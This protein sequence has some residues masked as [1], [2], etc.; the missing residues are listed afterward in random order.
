MQKIKKWYI[1][2]VVLN[3][4]Y[5]GINKYWFNKISMVN[6]F[7]ALIVVLN[8]TF[9]VFYLFTFP[10]VSLVLTSFSFLFLIP[11]FLNRKRRFKEA[12]FLLILF[13]NFILVYQTFM[14]GMESG[15]YFFYFP[16]FAS[17]FYLFF[18]HEKWSIFITYLYSSLGLVS[19]YFFRDYTG[20][21]EIKDNGFYLSLFKM[22]F[23]FALFSTMVAV[24][25]INHS[26]EKQNAKYE[27]KS[28]DKKKTNKK[29]KGALKEKSVLLAE[30]HHR[31][32][33]NLAVISGLINLQAHLSK[34]EEVKKVLNDSAGRIASMS[35]IHEK[36]YKH[37]DLSNVDMI[38]YIKELTGEIQNTLSD[39][40]TEIDFKYDL[41]QFSLNIIQA[42]P[43]GLIINELITNCLK[44]AFK[45]K[46]HGTVFISSTINAGNVI[47]TVDDD[48]IGFDYEKNKMESS[49]LG[50]I[51][52]ESLVQQLKGISEYSSD[53]G[54][55]TKF[56]LSFTVKN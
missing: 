20:Y 46:S 38:Q 8:M 48:G 15:N 9:A 28:E 5:P 11:Y 47:I 55:G 41:Q 40:Q 21:I 35:L 7:V 33:N 16:L 45:G 39:G 17:A 3:G 53:S 29:L 12:R 27:R 6:H 42:V 44:H 51:I 18:T 31:V 49:S 26:M 34:K 13:T 50:L 23:V 25:L 10:F 32:K 52:I 24:L 37:Q 1:K 54:S 36:I 2:N 19:L 43:C 4:F 30:V 22:N 14:L 56:I